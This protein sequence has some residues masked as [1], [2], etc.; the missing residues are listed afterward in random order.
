MAEKILK[1]KSSHFP[2]LAA[3]HFDYKTKTR[4]K[5]AQTKTSKL[6]RHITEFNFQVYANFCKSNLTSQQKLGLVIA[7]SRNTKQH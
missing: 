2:K 1:Y 7:I 6:E 4:V 3:K 5:L